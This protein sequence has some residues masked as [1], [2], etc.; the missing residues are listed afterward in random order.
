MN[1][2]LILHS[3]DNVGVLKNAVEKGVRQVVRDRSLVVSDSLS[4]GHKVA[5]REIRKGEMVLKY[6][7][8][9]GLAKSEIPA[10]AHVHLHNLESRYT[11]IEDME[12]GQ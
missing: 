4:M 12:T 3:D 9:I 10:G 2:L 1:E 5:I 11:Q 7:V 8:C 6:G